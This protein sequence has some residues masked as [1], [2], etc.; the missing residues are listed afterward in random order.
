MFVGRLPRT[1]A[2]SLCERRDSATDA[3]TNLARR[4]V[5]VEG[6]GGVHG[7]GAGDR[8][9]L[10][11]GHGGLSPLPGR[12]NP[13]GSDPARRG[14]D[15]GTTIAP[16]TTGFP[17]VAPGTTRGA[18]RSGCTCRGGA[19]VQHGRRWPMGW[20]RGPGVTGV[21]IRVVGSN[22]GLA[23]RKLSPQRSEHRGPHRLR[24]GGS[25]VRHRRFPSEKVNCRSG[26][27]DLC[28]SVPQQR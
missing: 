23:R 20:R 15:A 24:R 17:W 1:R 5:C 8:H 7:L 3:P 14:R 21:V 27:S 11:D 6:S 19:S 12:K 16:E 10:E 28:R 22:H 13:A 26:Q 9:R 2:A 4:G 25:G 18:I